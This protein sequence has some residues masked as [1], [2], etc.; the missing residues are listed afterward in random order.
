ME[1]FLNFLIT[2]TVV[3]APPAAIRAIRR[4]RLSVGYSV[5]IVVVLYLANHILF[6]EMTGVQS[7]RGYLFIGAIFSFYV[8]RWQTKASAARWVAA[9]RHAL[10]YDDPPTDPAPRLPQQPSK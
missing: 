7:S 10:G 3:L 9:E 8:L 6:A 1:L 2:W 5:A 4:A